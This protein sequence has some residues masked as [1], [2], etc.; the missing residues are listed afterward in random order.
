VR[1]WKYVIIKTK[2]HNRYEYSVPALE[3]VNRNGEQVVIPENQFCCIG[4]RF[5]KNHLY[6]VKCWHI[7]CSCMAMC[8]IIN[9]FIR[10]LCGTDITEYNEYILEIMC[11]TLE[12]WINM[13]WTCMNHIESERPDFTP[14][15]KANN[16][17][18]YFKIIFNDICVVNA[19]QC[20]S[21]WLLFWSRLMYV[22]FLEM[23]GVS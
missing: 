8:F 5:L 3:Y 13:S 22:L 20:E 16:I 21:S 1:E 10:C 2:V 6:A 19:V 12:K 9:M 11:I 23:Q 14:T 17:S 18:I 4:E 15:P 7:F